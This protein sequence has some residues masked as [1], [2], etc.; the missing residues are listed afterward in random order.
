MKK[1]IYSWHR[2]ASLIIAIP[3]LLW[4]ASGFMHPLMT[5]IRPKV[6]TQWMMPKVVDSAKIKVPLQE[7][8]LKNHIDSF[9]NFRLI[10]IDTN[11]FYQVQR[12]RDKEPVY[13]STLTGKSL[14]AGNQLYA[15]YIA[16]VYLEGQQGD[17]GKITPHPTQA[18]EQDCCDAA[19]SCVLNNTKGSKV[20]NV[21]YLTSF[22]DE[23][24]SI[25]RLLPVYKVAFERTDGIRVYVETTQDKFAFAM[26]DKRRTFDRIFTLIHT[27]T[28]LDFLGKGKLLVEFLLVAL[29]FLTTCMGVYIFFTTKHKK[30]KGNELVKARRN[31]RYTSIVIALFTLMFTFS[32]AYHALAKFKDDTRNSFYNEHWFAASTCNFDYKLLQSQLKDPIT[33]ISLAAMDKGLTYWQ[34]N[35]KFQNAIARKDLMKDAQ[36][37]PPNA[38]YINTA[39]N[40]VL[41]EGEVVYARFLAKIFSGHADSEVLSVSPVTKFTNEYNFTDKRLPVWKVSYAANSNERYYVETSTGKLSKSINDRDLAEG[42]SFAF[43]HKHE[44]MAW[45][46]KGLK[47][48]STMFWAFAQIVMVTIG[49]M[50][51]F[52]WRKKQ[53][54]AQS[55]IV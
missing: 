2:T 39:D 47:D 36:V 4:A 24:K 28:W 22:D 30:V 16:K 8:L 45:G 54:K 35:T 41:P 55:S 12:G 40:T 51:Y 46:G 9:T 38:V 10:H 27:W 5:N 44:F 18:V 19:A 17:S 53:R 43:F 15:Q 7:A 49:L 13:L 52:K 14:T 48:F 26:D 34:V 29:A 25:N 6:A 50:L 23:Y 33:N 31:H 21:S 42:Y 32:G 20:A 11:W 1:K 37:S 3:V